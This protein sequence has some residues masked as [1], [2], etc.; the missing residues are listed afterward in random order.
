MLEK[1]VSIFGD[2]KHAVGNSFT[3]ADFRIY[4]IMTHLASG[5]MEKSNGLD[6]KI[7]FS[8][9]TQFTNLLSIYKNVEEDPKT[10]EWYKK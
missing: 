10:K 1:R 8:I 3:I 4:S 5:F 6:G 2:G 9:Y 7:D